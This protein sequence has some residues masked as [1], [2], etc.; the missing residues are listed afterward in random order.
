M[1]QVEGHI[2]KE[3]TVKPQH[4]ALSSHR[5]HPA[6]NSGSGERTP[7]K[8]THTHTHTSVKEHVPLLL[9]HTTRMHFQQLTYTS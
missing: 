5:I 7:P 3:I 8:N 2:Y 9:T 1:H 6:K 4:N